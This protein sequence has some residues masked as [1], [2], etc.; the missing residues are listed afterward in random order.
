MALLPLNVITAEKE[1]ESG[2][3]C[4]IKVIGING[5]VLF[6]FAICLVIIALINELVVY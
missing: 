4:D 6:Y 2:C 5:R 1:R 3:L